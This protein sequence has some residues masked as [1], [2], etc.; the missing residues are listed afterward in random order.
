MKKFSKAQQSSIEAAVAAIE[1]A[2]DE[3]NT[4]IESFNIDMEEVRDEVRRSLQKYNDEL[5]KLK[6][7]YSELAGTAREYY[8]ERSD[9]WR[10]G[11]AGQAYSDW[12][13]EMENVD[14]EPIEIEFPD[15]L[16]EPDYP[17]LEE[18]VPTE[19]N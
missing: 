14:L 13:D 6:D 15:E 10:E 7:L 4:D 8:D 11:D 9:T 18:L 2:K 1:K 16:G 5:A 17:E 12:C 19:P 3:L